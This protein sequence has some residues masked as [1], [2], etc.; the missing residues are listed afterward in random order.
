[1]ANNTTFSNDF[2][3][4]PKKTDD[5]V[6][7]TRRDWNRIKKDT[8]G[9][10]DGTL[11]WWSI[12]LTSFIAVSIT[13]WSIILF[14]GEINN[15]ELSIT[16]GWMSNIGAVITAFSIKSVK[17]TKSLTKK[18]LQDDINYIED[19]FDFEA[20]EQGEPK[21]VEA[22]EEP[23]VRKLNKTNEEQGLNYIPIDLPQLGLINSISFRFQSSSLYW[24]TGFKMMEPNAS[25]DIKTLGENTALFHLSRS[26]DSFGIDIYPEG[27]FESGFHKTIKEIDCTKPINITIDRNE[28][29]FINFYINDVVEYNGRFSPELFKKAAILVWGDDNPYEASID[30][31]EYAYS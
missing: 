31:I 19:T 28:N 15:R 22:I 7:V 9:L 29:N 17:K 8:E 25:S 6:L 26:N 5:L 20:L 27:K 23:K 14:N 4:I 18:S 24:R 21:K 1:M 10:S 3:V 2:Q 11:D 30:K 16:L 12:L 13:L